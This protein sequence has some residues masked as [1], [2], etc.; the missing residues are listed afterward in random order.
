[1][2]RGDIWTVA[3]SGDYTAKPRPAVILQADRFADI[4]SVTVCLLSTEPERAPFVR[5]QVDPTTRNGLAERSFT[6]TDKL[7]TVRR[8]RLGRQ[9]GRLDDEDLYELEQAVLLFLGFVSVSDSR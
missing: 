6:M 4:E 1:M 2:K 8:S 7:S 3:G 5:I 9:V